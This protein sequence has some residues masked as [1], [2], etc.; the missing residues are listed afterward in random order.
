M[1]HL[2]PAPAVGRLGQPAA[3]VAD[4]AVE[5]LAGLL[6]VDHARLLVGVADL[7]Q[8]RAA[9][10]RVQRVGGADAPLGALHRHHRLQ[11]Q[12]QVGRPEHRSQLGDDRLVLGPGVVEAGLALEHE[13]H[14][15]AHADHA[16]REPAAVGRVAVD[17]HEVLHL[18]HA[19]GR[20]EA[21]DEDVGVGEVELLGGVAVGR[22]R[23]PVVAALLGVEDGR[24][25]ARRVEPLGA[26]PVDRA[27]GAD[28]GDRVQV[29]D[30][31]VLLD[32][33]VV[34]H[35][36]GAGGRAATARDCTRLPVRLGSSRRGLWHTHRGARPGAPGGVVQLV[37]TPACHA[38]G[39]GFESRRSRSSH[40][41][42][43]QSCR[44]SPGRPSTSTVSGPQSNCTSTADSS[45]ST[46]PSCP[47]ATTTAAGAW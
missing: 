25:H 1:H 38:G 33:K 32:R 40:P 20:Q 5:G 42:R 3:P 23:D 45:P 31:A 24:E 27:V 37:R 11:H 39:R 26:V 47:G 46:Q 6:L 8:E 34:R 13:G 41:A 10:A 16:P 30:D 44:C 29:A 28:Q 22:R 2:A 43:R 36:S 17:G 21:G 7:Q 35:A 19:V 15:A 4:G 12:R 18:A 14:L 9:V